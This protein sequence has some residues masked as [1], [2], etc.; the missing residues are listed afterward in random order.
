MVTVGSLPRELAAT[1]F[2]FLAAQYSGRRSAIKTFTHKAPEFVFWIFPEGKLF[3]AKDAH[4]K[5]LPKGFEHIL[6][7][8]PDYG[9][10]LRGR[11]VRSMD[12]FQLV[13][14]YCREEALAIQGKALQQLLS[15]LSQLPIP[16]DGEALVVSDNADI[17]GTVSDLRARG[18]G[19]EPSN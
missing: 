14:V 17:Y 11:V 5:N 4:R 16:L 10:F 12:G 1:R 7:D 6:K 18:F 19:A 15:G 9:G 2:P 3:D 8:E 13:V